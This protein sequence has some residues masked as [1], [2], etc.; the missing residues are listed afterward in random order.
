MRLTKSTMTAALSIANP[1]KALISP[2]LASQ[3]DFIRNFQKLTYRR[4]QLAQR[5]GPVAHGVFHARTHL[6]KRSV[7]LQDEEE[8][9][10]AETARAA[11]RAYDDTVAAA[12]GHG[13]DL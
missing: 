13:R 6:A 10:V 7:V 3:L 12:F 11:R 5:A 8:R 2:R 9:I 4:A 1:K